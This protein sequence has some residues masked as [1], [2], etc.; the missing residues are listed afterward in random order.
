M[1]RKKQKKPVTELKVTFYKPYE[2]A[3]GIVI[4]VGA[5]KVVTRRFYEELKSGGYIDK[6]K[7]IIT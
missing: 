3:N 4:P 1:A 5:I 7:Q 6:P 2:Y